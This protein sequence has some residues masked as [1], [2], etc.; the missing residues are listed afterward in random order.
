MFNQGL[1]STPR[2]HESDASPWLSFKHLEGLPEALGET[3]STSKGKAS[4]SRAEGFNI[5]LN[6]FPTIVRGSKQL[7]LVLQAVAL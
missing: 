1:Q 5:I 6:R 3:P 2:C 7:L 4:P